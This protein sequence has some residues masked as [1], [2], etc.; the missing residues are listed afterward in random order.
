MTIGFFIMPLEVR[1]QIYQLVVGT[2]DMKIRPYCTRQLPPT[3]DRPVKYSYYPDTRNFI[4]GKTRQDR[5]RSDKQQI[6]QGLRLLLLSRQVYEEASVVLFGRHTLYLPDGPIHHKCMIYRKVKPETMLCENCRSFNGWLQSEEIQYKCS[7]TTIKGDHKVKAVESP[8]S[9]LYDW[10][11]LIGPHHAANIRWIHLDSNTIEY[12]CFQPQQSQPQGNLWDYSQNRDSWFCSCFSEVRHYHSGEFLEAGL[13]VLASYGTLKRMRI[14]FNQHPQGHP[15]CPQASRDE[16]EMQEYLFDTTVTGNDLIAAINFCNL[17]LPGTRLRKV[18]AE[19]KTL[20]RFEL[21]GEHD[22]GFPEY[23]VRLYQAME[24]NFNFL[25][26][27]TGWRNFMKDF[28]LPKEEATTKA[29]WEALIAQG[30][31]LYNMPRE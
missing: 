29:V 8:K 12:T 23:M 28:S 19:F 14:S 22:Q 27:F 18:L 5:K 6:H 25:K 15:P 31:K 30:V 11:N 2:Q 16:H 1:E 10:V 20:E 4:W 21:D 17:F 26:A 24:L 3:G 13:R 9:H 7:G